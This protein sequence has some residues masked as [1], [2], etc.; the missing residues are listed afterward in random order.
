MKKQNTNNTNE[1]K[2]STLAWLVHFITMLKIY[3]LVPKY[4]CTKYL[5][6]ND[7]LWNWILFVVVK[8]ELR[9]EDNIKKKKN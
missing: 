2:V 5:T 6:K 1:K 9:W 4:E 3:F 7:K 8:V